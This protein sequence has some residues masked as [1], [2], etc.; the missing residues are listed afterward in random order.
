MR[1]AVSQKEQQLSRLRG[2]G[3]ERTILLRSK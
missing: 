1:F 3:R 2:I